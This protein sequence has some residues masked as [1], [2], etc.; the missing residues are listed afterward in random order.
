[1]NKFAYWVTDSVTGEWTELPDA[2]PDAISLSRQI[3]RLFTGNLDAEVVSNP[4]FKGKEKDLLRAQIARITMT[5]TLVPKG[6][7]I[8]AEGNEREVAEATAEEGKKLMPN[9]E[10]LM[11]LDYWCHSTPNILK[12][13]FMDY[14]D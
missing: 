11:Q 10:Q 13:F 6:L 4:F 2:T 14:L 12:V 8:K 5:T 1:V 3:K 7:Y 9:F